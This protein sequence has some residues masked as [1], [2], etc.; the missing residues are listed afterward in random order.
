MFRFRPGGGIAVVT[1]SNFEAAP[2]GRIYQA[3]ALYGVRWVSLGTAEPDATGKARLIAE[4][5]EF[6]AR[7]E[8]L[9]VTEEPMGG[10]S[11]PTGADVVRWEPASS[12]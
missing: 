12:P 9:K 2:A 11:A 3:W 4:G 10:S 6:H 1:F 5:A 8:A 7:P